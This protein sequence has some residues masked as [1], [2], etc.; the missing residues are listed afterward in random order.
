[1]V[2]ASNILTSITK[3]RTPSITKKMQFVAQK[4]GVSVGRQVREIFA[5]R[6]GP[7]KLLPQEYYRYFVYDPALT[8]RQKR[9]FLG[10]R[11]SLALNYGLTA[12]ELAGARFI[13]DKKPLFLALCGA[14]GIACTETQA[15][16]APQMKI[17]PWRALRNAAETLAFLKHSARYPLYGKPTDGKQSIGGVQIERLDA[18]GHLRFGPDLQGPHVEA[19]VAEVLQKFPNGYLFQTCAQ[20]AKDLRGLAPEGLG[21]LRLNTIMTEQGQPEAY[22]G[23]LRLPVK[24]TEAGPTKSLSRI[25]ARLDLESST[26]DFA[27][28]RTGGANTPVDIQPATGQKLTGFRIEQ[29]ADAVA[30]VKNAHMLVPEL[31]TVG[32]DVALTDDG[33]LIIEGNGNPA[34]SHYQ[35]TAGRGIMNADLAPLFAAA[36]AR[37]D[38]QSAAIRAGKAAWQLGALRD[39]VALERGRFD[40]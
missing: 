9:E 28:D 11:A 31:G 13:V 7:G 19:F 25:F 6:Y 22:F 12:P 15:M 21:P 20:F 35:L 32:W 36:K 38:A 33:P 24:G 3:F 10:D 8:R 18:D 37:A 29:L 1:M 23:I 27:V 16:Y 2:E 17:G 26:I 14:S 39:V 4:H 40:S 30:L 34:Y 5:L